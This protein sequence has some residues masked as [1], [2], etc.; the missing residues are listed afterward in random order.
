M[1]APGSTLLKLSNDE[2]L[3]NSAFSFNL[4]RYNM[5]LGDAKCSIDEMKAALVVEFGPQCIV[6]A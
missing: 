6:P 2:P 5:V 4:R 1:K 3:S